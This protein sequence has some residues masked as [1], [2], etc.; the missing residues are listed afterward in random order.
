MNELEAYCYLVDSLKQDS[1]EHKGVKGMKWKNHVYKAYEKGKQSI[2]KLIKKIRKG[3]RKLFATAKY[4]IMYNGNEKKVA[5]RLVSKADKIRKDAIRKSSELETKSIAVPYDQNKKSTLSYEGAPSIGANANAGV[6]HRI[7]NTKNKY[8]KL[9]KDAD[10][11]NSMYDYY[12]K[13]GDK[14]TRRKVKAIRK[15]FKEAA[16][17]KRIMNG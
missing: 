11:I 4:K 17:L 3:L 6:R 16:E 9:K 2:K 5:K 15:D 10:L 7:W 13:N 8:S 14:K 12:E 1:L